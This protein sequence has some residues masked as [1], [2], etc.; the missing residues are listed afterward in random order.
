MSIKQKQP[1]QKKNKET[2]I[3]D[4]MCD[5][6]ILHGF[7]GF[8]RNARFIKGRKFEADFWWP[9][10]RIALEV[11]GGIWLPRSGHTSGEGYTRDRERD[12]KALLQGILTVRFTSD[13]VKNGFAIASF[14]GIFEW[15]KET[16]SNS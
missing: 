1:I 13:Q 16:R 3:E 12:A 14:K 5:Q 6:L 15:W 9:E 8:E 10:H 11:D 4:E 7:H 2:P